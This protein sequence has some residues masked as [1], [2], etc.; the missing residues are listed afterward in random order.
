MSSYQED[1]DV[2]SQKVSKQQEALEQMKKQFEQLMKGLG[3]CS[4]LGSNSDCILFA[5]PLSPCLCIHLSN[6]EVSQNF[7]VY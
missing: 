7:A 4:Q 5:D 6:P 3:G 2:V 1:L